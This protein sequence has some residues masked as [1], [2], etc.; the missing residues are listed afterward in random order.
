MFEPPR[1][2]PQDP[3]EPTDPTEQRILREQVATLYATTV[4]STA[5]DTVIAWGLC[6][7]LYWVLRDP[8]ILVWL[9]LHA[10]QLLRSPLMYAYFRDPLASE[11]SAFWARRQQRE[12]TYYSITWGLAP[13]LFLPHDNMALTAVIML[14]MLGLSSGGVPSVAPRWG[15]VLAFALPMNIGLITALLWHARDGTLTFLYLAACCAIYLAVTLHFARSQHK[16]LA[17]AL[18]IRFEKEAL[19]EDLARQVIATQRASEEKTRFLAAASHDLRQPL[20]AIALFGAVLDKTLQGRAAHIHAQRLMSAVHTLGSSLD[21][22]LDVSRLDAGVIEARPVDVPL[23]AIMQAL[24]PLFATRAEEEQL[25]LRLRATPLWVRTDPQLL[26]RMLANLIENAIKYTQYGGVVVV[27]RARGDKVWVD[28]I[29]TGIGIE[30]AHLERIFDEF[31]QVGNAGRDR[32]RG[33]GIGLSIV[34][35]LSRLLDHPVQVRSHPGRGSRF[36]VELPAAL[37]ARLPAPVTSSPMHAQ[38]PRRVLVV[39]DEK[40]IADAMSAFLASWGIASASARDEYGAAHLLDRAQSGT[41]PFELMIC[42]FRLAE[43]ADGLEA[44]QRLREHHAPGIPLLLLTGETSPERLQRVRDSG[45]PVL[46]KP[47][48]ADR[49][50]QKIAEL[51][52]T[53]LSAGAVS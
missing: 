15:S 5:A 40:D 46:F 17:A 27:A 12:L 36:R 19:A 18:K 9:G 52:P 8:L 50:L 10:F 6:A 31:Y 24:Q 53:T 11:R 14:V 21:T 43:G 13:W 49:L 23:N 48:Q 37:P 42:D 25:Q 1:P 45:V 4:S 47:V 28:V 22:M 29:D 32:A 30:P 35:R 26:H 2:S 39:D 41:D 33:L 38:L 51:R 3:P 34:H 16:L 7:V 44:A 20:H